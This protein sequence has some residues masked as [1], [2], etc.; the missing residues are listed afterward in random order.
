M[1]KPAL[2]CILLALM[3]T[4]VMADEPTQATDNQPAANDT[5][6]NQ[7]ISCAYKIPP[8]KTDIDT[9][10]VQSWAKYATVKSFDMDAAS[11]DQQMNSL[12]ECFT[13]QGWEGYQN[14]LEK[15][16][17]LNAIKTQ[18]L[19]VSSQ[20]D[21]DVQI[22][23]AKTNQWK[24]TLPVEVV[25]QNDKQKLTQLLSVD[26]LVGRKVSGDLGIMQLIATP[27]VAGESKS[28]SASTEEPTSKESN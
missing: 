28:S 6:S 13:K 12:K 23:P 24:V 9:S 19:T 3:A 15:S 5:M 21:G 17:N 26:V 11:L 18:K 22:N 4:S 16:G 1:K 25:Y 14:A 2:F 7:P 8:E 20:V 10:I 27:R